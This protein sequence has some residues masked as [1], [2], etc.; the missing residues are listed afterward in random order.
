MTLVPYPGRFSR[1]TAFVAAACAFVLVLAAA[2]A[3]IPLYNTYRL[4]DGLSNADL[5]L[6]SV[7]YFIA[8]ASSLL[9]CAR[10]SNFVGRRPIALTA[11]L[12]TALGRLI[13]SA[14]HSVAPM[15]LGRVLQGLACGIASSRSGL[16]GG[17]GRRQTPMADGRHHRQLAMVA[18]TGALTAGAMVEAG[19]PRLEAGQSSWR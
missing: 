5:A 12:S 19:T 10:L 4:E 7:A 13:L 18:H 16:R 1:N 9:I 2:G 14:M 8:A 11:L 17:Y 3:P 15:L 6:V